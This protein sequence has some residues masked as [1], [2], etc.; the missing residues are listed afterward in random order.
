MPNISQKIMYENLTIVTRENF[1]QRGI[2]HEVEI[3]VD[4]THSIL[5][6]SRV[7]HWHGGAYTVSTSR[8]TLRDGIVRTSLVDD[9]F[10]VF[11]H[12]KGT[13]YSKKNLVEFG[14]MVH[15]FLEENIDFLV[16][17][18]QEIKTN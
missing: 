14:T 12:N 5:L 8:A 11:T 15:E 13:R 16:E 4:Y 3:K 7:R 2:E 6:T 1:E 9:D 10:D 17:W 18:A